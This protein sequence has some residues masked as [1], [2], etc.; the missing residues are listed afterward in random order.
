VIIHEMRTCVFSTARRV[1]EGHSSRAVAND[2]A[3]FHLSDLN[4]LQW[5]YNRVA[6]EIASPRPNAALNFQSAPVVV[7]EFKMP[8]AGGIDQ[9]GLGGGFGTRIGSLPH[10]HGAIV[11][12]SRGGVTIPCD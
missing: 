2:V 8:T 1:D 4:P 9:L 5:A 6:S 11:R 10:G 7:G 3:Q 12:C